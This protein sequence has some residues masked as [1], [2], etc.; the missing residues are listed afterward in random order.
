MANKETAFLG[1]LQNSNVIIIK[2]FKDFYDL[3]K[4]INEAGLGGLQPHKGLGVLQ[5]YMYLIN[6]YGLPQNKS[7]HIGWDG[8]TLYAECQIGK[9]QISYY[10]YDDPKAL[11]DWYGVKP[12]SVSEIA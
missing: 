9:E 5:D 3:D 7:H 4:R 2:D 8:Q 1:F 11:E 12:L 6:L 10:P